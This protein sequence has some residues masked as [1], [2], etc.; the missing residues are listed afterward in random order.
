MNRTRI[1]L[2]S[3][4]VLA[5]V[6][7]AVRWR[8]AHVA[9]PDFCAEVRSKIGTRSA[10]ALLAKLRESHPNSAE[11]YFLSAR[12]SRLEGNAPDAAVHAARAEE[13]GWSR[14]QLARER[15]LRRAVTDARGARPELDDLL[16]SDPNDSDGLAAL[17]EGALQAG[18]SEEAVALAG[19]ILERDPHDPRGLYLRGKARVQARQLDAA[20]ADLEAAVA[21][22]PEP[23]VH[24]PARLALAMCL[25]DLGEFSR[26]FDL[27]C[28]ARDEGPSDPLALFGVGRSATYLGRLD[29]AER[30]FSAVLELR[31]GHVE[32]LVSLAQ[33]VEQRGDL[34]RALGYL[35][36][37]ERA[38]PDRR[39][40]HSRLAKI[41][42]A[43]GQDEGAAHHESRF[44]ALDPERKGPNTN[45]PKG[46]P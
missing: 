29:D 19:R 13:L 14:S 30:A 34:K 22:G 1:V 32:T 9:P 46:M 15:V 7:G 36:A 26:A 17:A 20:R 40:T 35:E 38:E 41:L 5:L 11:V 33:V 16:A 39:E 45:P 27:F 6:A 4:V 12:Q 28:A 10:T 18:R 44:R 2:G 23:L 37:A 8:R 43:L 24:A 25:L 42:A 31:P 3:L 21:A